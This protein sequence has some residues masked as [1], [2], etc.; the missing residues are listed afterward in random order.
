MVVSMLVV[1][2]APAAAAG[3][4]PAAC[5]IERP[6]GL[7]PP[8]FYEDYW[9]TYTH[10]GFNS[11]WEAHPRPVGTV[12][13][14]MLF[15]DFPDRPASAVTQVSPIDYRQPQAYYEFLK[16]SVEWFRTASYGR[17]NLE[18]T[19]IFKWY[20]MPRP[21][22]EWRMDYRSND[23]NRRLSADGQG[24]FTA[25]AVAAADA[26]VDFS[27]YDLIYTVPAR[28]QTAIASS[29][30]LNNYTH[31]IIAD[32]N[33]LGNGD[34]FGG[35]MFSWGYKLLVHET[36]HAVSLVEGYN[37]GTGGTFRYMGQWDLMGN[38][39]GNAPDYIAWNKWKIGW[40]TDDEVDCVASDGVTEH[41]L[42]ANALA[43]DGTSKKLVAIRTGQHTTL[44]AELRAPLGTDSLAGGN[45]ARYCE[46]GGILLYTVDTTLRNG[47]GVYKVLDAMPG[48]T[49]WGCGDETSISTMGRGQGRGPSHFEVPELGV[50]LDLTGISADGTRAT[51]KVTRQDTKITGATSGVAPFTTTLTG[52]Q[53]NAPADAS[54]AWDFGDGTT[55]AGASVQHTFATPG[56]YTVKLTVNG[57]TAAQT[58]D[59]SAPFTGTLELSGP[60]TA[61]AGTTASFTTN[62]PDATFEVRRAGTVVE[63]SARYSSPIAGTDQVT[64][65]V[66]AGATC[67]TRP[68][69]WTPAAGWNELW[70]ATTLSG[71]TYSG[72]GAIARNAM[73]ALGTSGGATA[74]NP[75]ALTYTGRTFRDFH[76]QLSYRVTQTSNNGGVLLRN[77][78]QVAILD[79]GT[80]AT[81]TGAILNVAPTTSAQAKPTREWNT[82]DVIAYGDRITSL[83]NGVRVASGISTRAQEGTIALE[84]AGNNLM[85]ADVRI[86]ALTT[87]TTNPAVTLT[88][89]RAGQVFLQGSPERPDYDCADDQDL[90]ECV[91]TPFSTATP[92]RFTFTVTARDAAGNET[93]VSR[94]YSVV[95]Y[96]TATQDVGATVPATL[97]LTLEGPASFGAFLPGQAREY[98]ATTTANVVST[99]GDA[100]LTVADPGHLTNGAF[101]LPQ[102]LRV[103]IAPNTWTGPVSNGQSTITF[104][105]SIGATDAV[106]TGTYSRTLTFTLSTTTP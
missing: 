50:T 97:S 78:E 38:I 5:K 39:S 55:G 10:G 49:S 88:T 25:A 34:N 104:K 77:G 59:V 92:G 80:A 43:P 32:G 87:D 90:I 36:G 83:V 101:T 66:N 4:P 63:R 67:V 31:Q 33:D 12:K 46:S 94:D 89:P 21:S 98:T 91:A 96:T 99:A 23:P 41:T 11:D 8:Y 57:A 27:G 93:A 106:R 14:V 81:R 68:I 52:S 58:V 100:A 85:Y 69:E 7:W 22:T 102:P 74:A 65:C 44:V 76:L 51:L 26:E 2:A 70:D 1:F 64:A 62:A 71:W 9:N 42:S 40:L 3:D 79:N 95:A 16:Q 84:N 73:T 24:E 20:R 53:R 15:V 75:G 37:A 61:V 86:K 35:D 18:I 30:E 6:A 103:E 17:F 47:L 56:R 13:A 48:S 45:T 72:A 19:P 60:D 54:Y 105:Q 29:P 28:N 82:L